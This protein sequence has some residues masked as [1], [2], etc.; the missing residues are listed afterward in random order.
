MMSGMNRVLATGDYQNPLLPNKKKAYR[1]LQRESNAFHFMFENDFA[2]NGN[3]GQLMF[4]NTRWRLGTEWRLGYNNSHGYETETHVG[5]F[6]GRNQWFMPFVGF[7]W[8]Y[9]RLGMNEVERNLFGQKNTKDNRTQFSLGFAY[10]LPLLIVLQAEVYQDGNVRVQL[11][12]EDIPISRRVRGRFMVNTDQEF[13]VGIDYIFT[14]NFGAR[15]HYD[16]DMGIG[17]G[18]SV[19]Y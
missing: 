14:K 4:Q 18:V 19:T 17:I 15:V 10:T 12:R 6:I 8:R 2:S 16:S 7:D 11:S 13:M 1:A 3:D 9:R 5:R